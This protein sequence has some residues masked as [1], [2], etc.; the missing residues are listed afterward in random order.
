MGE[1]SAVV[2]LKGLLS[3]QQK[4]VPLSI[5]S[6]QSLHTGILAYLQFSQKRKLNRVGLNT[7]QTFMTLQKKV[8]YTCALHLITMHTISDAEPNDLP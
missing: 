1:F 4:G 5:S 7:R 3:H 6:A 2:P 8:R